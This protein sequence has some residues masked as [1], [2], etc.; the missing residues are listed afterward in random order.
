M[1][2]SCNIYHCLQF[3][4]APNLSARLTFLPSSSRAK[5]FSYL[6]NFYNEND[7]ITCRHRNTHYRRLSSMFSG[8]KKLLSFS[9]CN[10]LRNYFWWSVST[11][12]VWEI[13]R[14]HHY[15]H[16]IMSLFL[17]LL[18]SIL[19]HIFISRS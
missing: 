17:Y 18:L 1:T 12:I 2:V 16:T 4:F 15:S 13:S 6:F 19:C 10:V 5:N 14:N 9:S 3:Q 8:K 7:I 11:L